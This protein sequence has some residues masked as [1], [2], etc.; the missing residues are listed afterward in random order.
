MMKQGQNSPGYVKAVKNQVHRTLDSMISLE[1][2]LP[3]KGH[4][5]TSTNIFGCY[6]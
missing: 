4:V 6:N 5:V 3:L 1:V 2:I